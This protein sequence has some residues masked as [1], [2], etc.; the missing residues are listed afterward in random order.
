V[1]SVAR[2]ERLV[3]EFKTANALLQNSLAYV[4]MF[5]VELGTSGRGG[6]LGPAVSALAAAMLRLTLDTSPTIVEDVRHR[7]A[8]LRQEAGAVGQ[9]DVMR[10]LLAHGELL[11]DLLPAAD[12][13]VQQIFELP[14]RDNQAA[15]RSLVLAR[16][17]QS[18]S[19]ARQY[20][21]YLYVSSLILVALLTQIASRLRARRRDL[22]RRAAFEHVL[23]GISMRFLNSH[24][25]HFD[26]DIEHALADMAFCIGADRAYFC[27]PGPATHRYFWCRPNH[28]LSPGWLE[29]AQSLMR[30]R[31]SSMAGTAHIARV[32]RLP[33]GEERDVLVAAGVQGWTC[34]M[35]TDADGNGQLLGFDCIVRPSRASPRGEL[36]LLR[37]A[38]DAIGSAL[39][40][41]NFARREAHL[42]ARLQQARRLE[43]VGALASGVAHNFNNIVGAII[44]YVEM[45]EERGG[46]PHV[47]QEIRRA[48]E[49]ARELVDQIL[50]F[51]RRRDMARH[52]VQVST[53]IGEALSLLRASLPSTVELALQ[54]QGPS[55]VA[56]GV[57]SQLQQVVLNLCTN[58]A[59]A[60]RQTG[61]VVLQI[62]NIDLPADR[63]QPRNGSVRALRAHRGERYRGWDR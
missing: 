50:A 39:D 53:I 24:W 1:E 40:R 22:R 52:P 62:E 30:R 37:M 12:R 35:R 5:G 33:R 36:G 61:R 7:L 57:A 13:I 15:I 10:P 45:A 29:Q 17:S 41:K 25:Q 46:L 54:Q 18:R 63:T 48:G 56:L 27:S 59:Q 2:Q 38:L 19:T 20:R 44:G 31:Y 6:S 28:R 43:T 32:T 21:R 3:E 11:Y 34:V 9:D 16:Q 55:A 8:D 47:L 51:E 58:A 49:R 14:L 60:M 26:A 42:E 4:S 23:T